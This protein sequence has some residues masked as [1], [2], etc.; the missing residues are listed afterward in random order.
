MKGS[1][2][3]G[4][5]A[6]AG[7]ALLDRA[8]L[9]APGSL[10]EEAALRRT[11]ALAV[12]ATDPDRFL[13]AS[14]QYSRRFLR[15]PYAAQFAEPFVSGILTLKDS[16]DLGQV[17][18]AIAWMT[19]E[20]AKTVYLRLARRAAIDGDARLLA[21][22]SQRVVEDGQDAP[23]GLDP[24][25]ELYSSISS[26]TSETVD[27]VLTRLIE[28]DASKL[29]ASDRALLDAARAIATEVVA[30]ARADLPAAPPAD[31]A[32]AGDAPA[33][34]AR[35]AETDAPTG[36][37]DAAGQPDPLVLSARARLEEI[38]K[39]LEESEQ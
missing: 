11:L 1:V 24:R 6:R 38:D 22:A 17:E 28:L 12:M 20:Q 4:E 15:S 16:L 7:I 10:V 29:S 26:V 8:R 33:E 35:M 25:S 21:F 9:L 3:A 5:D 37:A 36:P 39:M 14:E 31:A 2:V 23:E 18:Q 13:R 19:P 34:P 30:P 27:E 32:I